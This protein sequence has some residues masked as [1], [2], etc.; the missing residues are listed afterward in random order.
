MK[1]RSDFLRL[2]NRLWTSFLFFVLKW[3]P[4]VFH[5]K[6]GGTAYETM[7]PIE[8]ALLRD[9]LATAPAP[10]LLRLWGGQD[11]DVGL[12]PVPHGVRIRVSAPFRSLP[13]GS[14]I[15]API[16]SRHLQAA[17]RAHVN[18]SYFNC[19][20][21]D[22]Q[23]PP[24]SDSEGLARKLSRE[25]SLHRVVITEL[26]IE[27][28]DTLLPAPLRARSDSA[29]FVTAYDNS[30]ALTERVRGWVARKKPVSGLDHEIY[31]ALFLPARIVTLSGSAEGFYPVF[32]QTI[33]V[34]RPRLPGEN[35]TASLRLRSEGV[36]FC[37]GNV[38]RTLVF[39]NV[40][41][42]ARPLQQGDGF[43]GLF[44][45][46]RA[47]LGHTEELDL[48]ALREEVEA[49]VN[50]AWILTESDFQKK[51]DTPADFFSDRFDREVISTGRGWFFPA[52]RIRRKA[53][54]FF[55][56][57]SAEYRKPPADIP[58]RKEILLLADS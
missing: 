37:L 10:R 46:D 27:S 18:T 15:I 23:L 35:F 24:I 53:L 12:V 22:T 41:Q 49:P 36:R 21:P 2:R 45:A 30:P 55:S 31:A 9:R 58:E 34:T 33:A 51:H 39:H 50:R 11:L 8:T 25:V 43:P 4:R 54:R 3:L 42:L 32:E 48:F 56:L 14:N 20:S 7:L 52:V 29:F 13:L 19:I 6:R 26:A 57:S 5:W 17:C 16:Q 44:D 28:A 38:D 47:V 40:H 1:D